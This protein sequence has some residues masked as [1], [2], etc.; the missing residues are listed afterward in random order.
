MVIEHS[1]GG[2]VARA[3]A[4]QRT[5]AVTALALIDSGPAADAYIDQGML[6]RLLLAPIPGRLLWRLRTAGH[7][8]QA[9]SSAFTLQIDIPHALIEATLGMTHRALAGT[10]RASLDYLR[11]RSIPPG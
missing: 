9:L 8:P 2:N 10:A 3:L 1:T 7:H 4:E 5:D 11:Q 6:G